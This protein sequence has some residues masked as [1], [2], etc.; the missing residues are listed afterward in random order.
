MCSSHTTLWKSSL[1]ETY[2]IDITSPLLWYL[3]TQSDTVWLIHGGFPFLC[4]LLRILCRKVTRAPYS[5]DVFH[6]FLS[7]F[8][9]IISLHFRS[10]PKHPCIQ[11]TK[12]SLWAC[13]CLHPGQRSRWGVR[14]TKRHS[15][16]ERGFWK[17]CTWDIHL[18]V[19]RHEPT[20]KEMPYL[21]S[22]SIYEDVSEHTWC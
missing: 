12:A 9:P 14:E 16:Q 21:T 2:L 1:W 5:S 17:R 4:L 20:I 13:L 15:P 10:V 11:R 19:R 18:A 8:P 6:W 22:I 7:P 3:G